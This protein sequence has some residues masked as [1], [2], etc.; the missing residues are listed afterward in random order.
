MKFIKENLLGIYYVIILASSIL[1]IKA[2]VKVMGGFAGFLAILIFLCLCL[3][4]N[5][6]RKEKERREKERR[7]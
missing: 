2:A 3:I 4:E 5:E 6:L 7:F 1:L